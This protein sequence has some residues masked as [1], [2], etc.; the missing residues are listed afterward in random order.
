MLTANLVALAN[1]RSATAGG[2][3][4]AVRLA[5]DLSLREVAAQIGVAPSTLSRWENGER[6]PRGEAALRYAHLLEELG[7][8]NQRR[9]GRK[10]VVDASTGRRATGAATPKIG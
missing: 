3:A 9:R 7:G 1:V 2:A 8:R 5:A 6:R 10:E 4:R